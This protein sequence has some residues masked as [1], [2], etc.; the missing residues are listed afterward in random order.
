MKF[1]L[2][3]LAGSIFGVGILISGMSN[4][5]KVVNFFDLFGSWDP[6]LAFVMGGAIAVASLGYHMV[7]RAPKPVFE[8]TFVIPTSQTIDVKL[9]GGAATFGVGWGIAGFCPGGAIPAI[10]T[11]DPFVILFILSMIIGMFVARTLIRKGTK[12]PLGL[13]AKT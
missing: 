4:P 1:L 11:G 10:G 3:Y 13:F 7:L 6:S 12:S 5:A 2:T 9:V 8:P